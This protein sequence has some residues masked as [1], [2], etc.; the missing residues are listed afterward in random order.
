M[1]E[2]TEAG[3][4]ILRMIREKHPNY[5]PLLSLADIALEEDEDGNLM[6]D[7]KVRVDCHKVITKYVESELRSVEVK[8]EMSADFG[9]L[10]VTILDDD[11]ED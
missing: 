7:V 3:N 10:R 6:H 11:D 8:G 9:H 2:N 1:M 5:H 4:N